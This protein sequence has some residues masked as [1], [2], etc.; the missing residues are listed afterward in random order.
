MAIFSKVKNFIGKKEQKE[1]EKIAQKQKETVR[2]EKEKQDEAKKSSKVSYKEEKGS[3]A[4]GILH[5]QHFSEKAS[6]LAEENKYVFVVSK[7]TNKI[8]MKDTIEKVYGVKVAT[9]NIIN[10]PKKK[11][12]VGRRVG[13]K[14]GFKKAV[15]TLKPGHKIEL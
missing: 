5:G 14:K 3:T 12:M 8:I 1:A 4:L 9:V 13:Y 15:V 10:I 6:Y 11:R 2:E 7:T